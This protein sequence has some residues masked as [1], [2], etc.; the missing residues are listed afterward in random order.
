MSN[1]SIIKYLAI[2]FGGTLFSVYLFYSINEKYIARNN[3]TV[4]TAITKVELKL[5]REIEK[6]NLAMEA[7]AVFIAN[8]KN[9]SSDKFADITS[10]FVEDLYGIMKLGWAPKSITDPAQSG[11]FGTFMIAFTNPSD[12]SGIIGQNLA[13]LI[14][15]S[16]IE[17]TLGS[18]KISYS[19]PLDFSKRGPEFRGFISMMLVVD[20]LG[21][22]QKGIV[23]GEFQMRELIERTLD[24]ELPI[25]DILILDD[26]DSIVPLY[27]SFPFSNDLPLNYSEKLNVNAA[28]RLW[29]IQVYPKIRYTKYPNALESYFVLLLGV[30]STLLLI[31]VVRQK[32][33]YGFDLLNEVRQRTYELEESNKLKENLLREIH[34]RVKNN[35]QITSSLINLQKRKLTDKETIQALESSQGRISAIALIHQKIYQDVSAKAVDLKGYLVD[36]INSHKNISPSVKYE[37]K[38]PEI[39]IDL[40]TAVPI[41][42]ITSE[43]VINAFKH[44]FNE[45]TAEPKLNLLVQNLEDDF[46]SLT[47]SDNGKGIPPNLEISQSTGLGFE[48]IQKLCRQINAKF[49]YTSDGSGTHFNLIFQQKG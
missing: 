25:L 7:S 41:A 34:H 8:N 20:T 48:I 46:I 37:I 2:F 31:M 14:M 24:F 36:L 26:A 30:L 4:E 42:L 21:R 39:S 33:Q 22:N 13:E 15:D 9:L 5:A 29:Q 32:D 19:M 27:S 38:C 12:T 40:D 6:I 17:N 45:V 44:A 23:F 49:S 3:A 16:G 43:L 35:L 1:A 10:P 18:K 11:R 28:N 47:I